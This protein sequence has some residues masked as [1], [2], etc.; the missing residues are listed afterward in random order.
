[1]RTLDA[2]NASAVVAQ[3]TAPV[4]LVELGFDSI[5]RFSTRE[6]QDWSGFLWAEASMRVQVG[7][8]P[9]VSIF[10][11]ATAIGQVL[12][13]EGPA[14]R[15]LK[16]YQRHFDGSLYTDPV[17]VFDGEMS[18]ATVG[19]QVVITGKRRP[20]QRTPRHFATS[21]WFNHVPAAG[22]RIETP[23]QIITLEKN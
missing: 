22:T 10:N 15:S 2:G 9:T 14:G 18:T 11:E 5:V 19:D 23:R 21:P 7:N 3:T 12:L 16:I 4:Y 13:T 6:L 8:T 1:M 17:L 20:P